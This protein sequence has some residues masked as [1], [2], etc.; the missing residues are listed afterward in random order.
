MMTVKNK[1]LLCRV[2]FCLGLANFFVFFVVALC[3]GG[4]AING[5]MEGGH[6][7]LMSHGRLTQV[8]EEVFAYSKWHA[9]SVWITH[10]CALIAAY[11]HNRLGRGQNA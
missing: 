4:D 2:I 11:W 7:Y 1:I 5:K 8:D 3:I 9:V 6:F 10:P